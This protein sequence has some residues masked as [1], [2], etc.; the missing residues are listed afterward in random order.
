MRELFETVKKISL[1]DHIFKLSPKILSSSKTPHVNPCPLCNHRDCFTLYLDSN[2]FKCFSCDQAGD[3]INFERIIKGSDSNLI[4]AQSLADQYGIPYTASPNQSYTPPVQAAAPPDPEPPKC[5]T[6][7]TERAHALRALTA[8]YFNDLLMRNSAALKYQTGHRGH[9]LATLTERKI[10][11]SDGNLKAYITHIKAADY[12]EADAI[13]VGIIGISATNCRPWLKPS[14]GFYVYPQFYN[15][16]VSHFTLKDPNPNKS[17]RKKWQIGRT[18]GDT[19]W[20]CYN[21]DQLANDVIIL[22]EG[23]DD[24]LTCIEN[25]APHTAAVIGNTNTH[26]LVSWLEQNAKGKTVYLAFDPDDAGRKYFRKYTEAVYKGGGC[27]YSMMEPLIIPGVDIDEYLRRSD[28]PEATLSKMIREAKRAAKPSTKKNIDPAPSP[29]PVSAQAPAHISEFTDETPSALAHELSTA[30]SAIPAHTSGNMDAYGFTSFKVLGEAETGS[31]VLWSVD[32][33]KVYSVT[34]KNL[35]YVQLVQIGGPE[36][37]ARVSRKATE[38]MIMFSTLQADIICEARKT[39]LSGVA[40]LGSGIHQLKD[41]RLLLV[42][43]AE[44]W[45]WDGA[46]LIQQIYPILDRKIL[47]LEP[48]NEWVSIP[49]LQA[50]LKKMDQPRAAALFAKFAAQIAQWGFVGDQDILV[51]SGWILAQIIQAAWVWRPHMWI[52]GSS[53]SGKSMLMQFVVAVFGKLVNLEQGQVITEAGLRQRM[54]ETSC[55]TIIDEFENTKDRKII[56]ELLRSAGFGGSTTKGNPDGKPMRYPIRHMVM[57]GSIETPIERSAEKHRYIVINTKKN[58]RL[59]PIIPPSDIAEAMKTSMIAYALW[60]CRPAMQI[61]KDHGPLDGVDNRY[62]ETLSVPLAM[63]A[64]STSKPLETLRE[65]TQIFISCED[66]FGGENIL[67]D[68]VSLLNDILLSRIHIPIED[69]ADERIIYQDRTIG[70]LLN[71]LPMTKNTDLT[72]QSHGVRLLDEGIFIHPSTL[73]N[74]LSTTAPRWKG[75]KIRGMLFRLPGVID[76]KKY[77]GGTETRGLII[78]NATWRPHRDED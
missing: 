68:E 38:G 41:N 37:T 34:L 49:A 5:L 23:E 73:Q 46:T 2:S 42:N 9:A 24:A 21:Q 45:I 35:N 28:N 44:A 69:G 39:P 6:I 67:E 64:V 66:A 4:A 12:T 60:A 57:L 47:S 63:A 17:A 58:E 43:G 40:K 19:D 62:I 77:I 15:G 65:N 52:T 16:N 74:T 48:G 22:V 54:G 76:T 27:V 55:M 78:P 13:A 30:I 7:P 75:L 29:E 70:Q 31:V 72:L 3:I 20:L 18:A 50:E 53:A 10:G 61:V 36:I 26:Y 8:D 51:V 33:R 32:S 25:G 14:L 59:R 56:I 1:K 71:S 11:W